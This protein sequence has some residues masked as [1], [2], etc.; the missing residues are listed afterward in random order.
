MKKHIICIL[1]AGALW[2]FMGFFVRLLSDIG[3]DSI[4]A[5]QIRCAIAA[6]CFAIILLLKNRSLFKVRLKDIWC[7]LGSGFCALLF[8]SYCYFTSMKYVSL[9]TA[10]ILLYTAPII[11]IILSIPIFREKLTINKVIAV[12]AAFI[13][14]GLV[15]G[16]GSTTIISS[17]G[18]LYGLGAGL[19]YALYSIFAKLALQRGYNSLT[20]NFY[21]CLCAAVG[22]CVIWPVM[23]NLAIMSVSVSNLSLAVLAGILTC[24]L[25]YLLYTYGLSGLETGKASILASSEPVVATLVGFFIFNETIGIKGL[26]GII[27]VLSA[28]ILV[29]Q[30]AVPFKSEKTEIN[31]V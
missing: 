9:S 8:F 28:I 30:N 11:V 4:G 3:I 16:L 19:G 1:A 22:S 21:S 13:G 15:S 14:C 17:Y 10:A 6:V 29:N 27:L 18:L 31:E 25:P 2:G 23:K 24:F 26:V 12:I 5:V 7:F 20:I